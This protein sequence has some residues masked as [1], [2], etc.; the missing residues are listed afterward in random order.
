VKRFNQTLCEKLAKIV[1]KSDSWNEFIKPT[2]MAYRI[3]KHFTTGVT[4]FVLIYGW[5]VILLIDEML[6]MMIR[7]HIIQI[8]EEISHIRE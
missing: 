7:D 1:D 2:L 8:I 5:E 6:S 4:P 3:T